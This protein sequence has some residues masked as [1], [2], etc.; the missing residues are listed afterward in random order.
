M[1][2]RNPGAPKGAA[3]KN[4]LLLSQIMRLLPPGSHVRSDGFLVVPHRLRVIDRS[5]AA[6]VAA[7]LRKPPKK[8]APKAMFPTMPPQKAS[9][10]SKTMALPG[11]AG[12]G[13]SDCAAMYAKALSN[14]FGSFDSLPCVPMS[15]PTPTQRWQTT[16]R[17]S[18]ITGSGGGGY[19]FI[20]IAPF[21]AANNTSKYFYSGNLFVGTG[22]AT[23]GT[24]VVA[25][26]NT[27][28]PYNATAL[29]SGIVGRLVALG[30]RVRN[31]SPGLQ[32]G[33]VV[34]AVQVDD[35][36]NVGNFT[37]D[38]LQ[39][40]PD[41]VLVPQALADQNE[42]SMLAW[43]PFALSSL[44]WQPDDGVGS[45]ANPTMSI[46]CYAPS[47]TQQ[48]TIEYEIVEFWEYQGQ[49]T[50]VNPPNLVLSDADQVGFDRVLDA[51]QRIPRAPTPAEW[52][53]QMAYGL[54][55]AVAHS[56]SVARTIEDLVGGGRK[57]GGLLGGALGGILKSLVGFLA[58]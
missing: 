20:A 49:T 42:W 6:Q 17:G 1:P 50:S 27:Q 57:G 7:L 19:G 11:P 45:N 47:L 51:A 35:Q 55:E 23:S 9:V 36:Q 24:G 4:K 12:T 56:D 38:Q 53:Q 13:L 25:L 22:P 3:P 26:P 10:L 32:V 18:F 52:Q 39:A 29:G 16:V 43:R 8:L 21:V 30:V 15:P 41:A 40:L 37:F 44:D 46:H 54:V 58:I 34:V 31:I 2:K 33:G 14:P 5:P 28:L 48:Q